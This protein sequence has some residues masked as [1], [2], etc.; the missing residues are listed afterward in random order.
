MLFLTPSTLQRKRKK[1]EIAMHFKKKCL[2]IMLHLK[3]KH[4]RFCFSEQFKDKHL[5]SHIFNIKI[6]LSL[7]LVAPIR[8]DDSSKDIL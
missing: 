2:Q 8:F 7:V 6:T 3:V 5:W 1:K 4:N